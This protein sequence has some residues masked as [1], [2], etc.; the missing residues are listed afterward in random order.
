MAK[1]VMFSSGVGYFE[2]DGDV[3]RRAPEHFAGQRR[4][5]QAH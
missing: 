2:H 3:G 5:D 1:V 4:S